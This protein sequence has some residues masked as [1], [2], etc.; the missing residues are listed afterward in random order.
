MFGAHVCALK[1]LADMQA[2]GD[3]LVDTIF[4]GLQEQGRLK[5]TIELRKFIKLTI[6]RL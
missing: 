5:I 6:R 1:P 3:N 2:V 4:E